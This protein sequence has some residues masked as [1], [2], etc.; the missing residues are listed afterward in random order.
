MLLEFQ[1]KYVKKLRLKSSDE[2]FSRILLVGVS[3]DLIIHHDTVNQTLGQQARVVGSELQ[4]AQPAQV[5]A[6][7]R[8]MKTRLDAGGMNR[9]D[10]VATHKPGKISPACSWISVEARSRR[11]PLTNTPTG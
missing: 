11:A 3:S 5:L 8:S 9:P 6:L 2:K 10:Q 4:G 7:R 1:L